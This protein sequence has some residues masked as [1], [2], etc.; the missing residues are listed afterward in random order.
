MPRALL[1]DPKLILLT[2][3]TGGPHALRELLPDLCRATDLP[4]V[5]VQHMPKDITQ[6]LAT[7]LSKVVPSKVVVGEEG[8]PVERGHV[9]FAPGGIHMHLAGKLSA[10]KLKLV[11]GPQV[12]GVKPAA[13]ELF[14][15]AVV[16]GVGTAPV[17]VLT[18]MGCDGALHLPEL[19][20]GGARIFAQDKESSVV[21]GMPGA[22]VGTGSVH[23]T[24]PLQQI[25]G[26]VATY[27][28]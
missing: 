19:A 20:A 15:S 3:S 11:D 28:R 27:L 4:I 10:K 26:A 24:L 6:P 18:G 7:S 23:E 8:M 21:W 14:K 9:Y 17:I 25:A 5:A 1:G 16:M 13:D 2:S 12:Q 22:A